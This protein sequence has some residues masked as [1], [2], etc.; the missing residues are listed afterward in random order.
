MKGDYKELIKEN[1]NLK[2]RI[3]E[4]AETVSGLRMALN[5]SQ[6]DLIASLNKEQE[7]MG[8]NKQ[9]LKENIELLQQMRKLLKESETDG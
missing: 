7:L 4:L 6:A 5:T 9:L 3:H 8:M 2:D 1:E